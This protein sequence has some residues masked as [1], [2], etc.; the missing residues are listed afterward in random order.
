E[1]HQASGSACTT[2]RVTWCT[3]NTSSPNHLPPCTQS[4]LRSSVSGRFVRSSRVAITFRGF[5]PSPSCSV[6]HRD[7]R[8]AS[9]PPPA[10]LQPAER[11]AELTELLEPGLQSVEEPPPLYTVPML[12]RLPQ[13]RH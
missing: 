11:L 6:A 10:L 1:S 13:V 7:P 3:S 4:F 5:I 12:E 2:S 8:Q 9:T